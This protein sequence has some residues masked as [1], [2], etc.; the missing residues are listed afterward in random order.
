MD[1]DS[2]KQFLNRT[3][4]I[5]NMIGDLDKHC[6]LSEDASRWY[7][8]RS[9]VA[10]KFIPKGKLI[11][12]DDLTWKRPGTGIPPFMLENVVG[13]Q[14]LDA[15]LEDEVLSFEKVKLKQLKRA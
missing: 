7:A 2:L 5:K 14:A 4:F 15:I 6:L 12:E 1:Y 10:R 8:R 11:T 13:G 9:L 3:A